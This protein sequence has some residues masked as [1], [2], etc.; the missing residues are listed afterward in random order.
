MTYPQISTASALCVQCET[1]P[2]LGGHNARCRKCRTAV[3]AL[4]LYWRKREQPVLWS[5]ERPRQ[6]SAWE[7]GR[8][9]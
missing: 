7:Q 3:D 2:R 9:A 5:S 1:R 6:W 4:Y 8:A